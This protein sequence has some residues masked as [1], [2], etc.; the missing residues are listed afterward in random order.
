MENNP[1]AKMASTDGVSEKSKGK[2]PTHKGRGD[3]RVD[4]H[5]KLYLAISIWEQ[6]E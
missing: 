2:R 4:S 6:E 5:G 3:F 1:D